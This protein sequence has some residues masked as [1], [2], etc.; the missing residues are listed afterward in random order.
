MVRSAPFASRLAVRLGH[1]P[2][3]GVGGVTGGVIHQP[4]PHLVLLRLG[5]AGVDERR[6]AEQPRVN[7]LGVGAEHRIDGNRVGRRGVVFAVGGVGQMGG[8]VG[9][10]GRADVAAFH[11]ADDDQAKLARFLNQ[12]VVRLDAFPEVFIELGG[13][14]LDDREVRRDELALQEREPR[15]TKR[16]TNSL[17][18]WSANVRPSDL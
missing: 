4:I 16:H 11:V 18:H 13:L 7:R 8:G 6:Q 2:K 5:R 3:A 12:A 1:E 15:N 17:G 10:G 9:T 14:E